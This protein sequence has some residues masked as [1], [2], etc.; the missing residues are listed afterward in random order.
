MMQLEF[1]SGL[2]NFRVTWS[3]PYYTPYPKVT[4][5]N[6]AKKN[7]CPQGFKTNVVSWIRTPTKKR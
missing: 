3:Y 2:D 6:I 4:D 1:G 5:Q 7:Q